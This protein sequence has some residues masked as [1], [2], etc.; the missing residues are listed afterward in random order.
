M[1]TLLINFLLIKQ[2]LNGMANSYAMISLS[3]VVSVFLILFVFFGVAASQSHPVSA[4][5]IHSSSQSF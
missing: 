3:Y 1:N 5:S 4:P 2:F